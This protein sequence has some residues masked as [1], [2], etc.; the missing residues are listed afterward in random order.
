VLR[1]HRTR[2]EAAKQHALSQ[3]ASIDAL[4]RAMDEISA[5]TRRV[6]LDLVK[7]DASQFPV[8]QAL[9]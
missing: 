1:R 2:L 7:L 3:T 5:E 9:G 8:A 6:R 4:F